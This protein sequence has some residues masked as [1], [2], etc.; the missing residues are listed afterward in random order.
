MKPF[1]VGEYTMRNGQ[2]AVVVFELKNPEENAPYTLCGYVTNNAG[3]DRITQWRKDGCSSRFGD[4][5]DLMPRKK[6]IEQ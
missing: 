6:E 2:P 4:Y 1:T 3:E 5:Y